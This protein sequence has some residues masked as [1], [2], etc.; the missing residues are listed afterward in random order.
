MSWQEAIAAE[1][2]QVEGSMG[3][4]VELLERG[5]SFAYC[6]DEWFPMA[7]VFKVPILI[8]LFCQRDAGKIDLHQ[9]I[10]IPAARMS[11][12]GGLLRHL[13]A[14]LP[15]TIHDLATLMI[16][17][18]DNTAT[19]V[20]LELAGTDQVQQTMHAYGFARIS[21][22]MS[23][24]ELIYGA[25]GLGNRPLTAENTATA[26]ARLQQDQLDLQSPVYQ[27]NEQNNVVTPRE[28]NNILIALQQE[29]ILTPQSCRDVLA[30]LEKQ[31]LNARLPLLLP[32]Q[33]TLA[34]KTGSLPHI[35]ADAGLLT[36]PK[37]KAVLSTFGKELAHE[38]QAV[39]CMARIGRIVY[40]EL[41]RP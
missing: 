6:A 17:L 4:A 19:D 31:L 11:P 16:I 34:H 20:L 18:S 12:G 9:T 8:A 3:V 15:L 40:D 32:R 37:G 29:K 30:I 7:S 41:Q 25:A 24:K 13:S 27:W 10:K 22:R 35:R 26:T 14:E 39:L 21:I 36:T 2:T 38:E 23:C 28:M 1:I 33:A 5:E